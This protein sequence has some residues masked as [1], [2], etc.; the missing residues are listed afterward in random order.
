MSLVKKISLNNITNF[1]KDNSYLNIVERKK[2]DSSNVFF[3]EL[4]RKPFD[5]Y[6]VIK[7]FAFEFF[8][9]KFK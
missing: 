7:T 1:N 4:L 2:P 6:S 3:E 5:L 9:K 8:I